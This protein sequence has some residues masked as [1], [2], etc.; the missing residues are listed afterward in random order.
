MIR[1]ETA[2]PWTVVSSLLVAT[3][4]GLL[5]NP[6]TR[7]LL[8]VV[9]LLTSPVCYLV[10]LVP[11]D[12]GTLP[13]LKPLCMAPLLQQQTVPPHTRLIRFLNPLL[14][15]TG[16]MIGRVAVLKRLPTRVYMV[17]KLVFA[18]LTPPIQF[19]WGMPHPLVRCYMALDRGLM[20]FMV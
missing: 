17:K 1:T 10:V 9:I 12:L 11:T 3:E 8:A 19:R 20:L 15:L 14:V 7:V 2:V 5:K 6:L 16:R 13:S 18:W 4:L